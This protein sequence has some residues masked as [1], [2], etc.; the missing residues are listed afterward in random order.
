MPAVK[1]EAESLSEGITEANN[2]LTMSVISK[3]NQR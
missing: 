2:Q 3:K 1:V